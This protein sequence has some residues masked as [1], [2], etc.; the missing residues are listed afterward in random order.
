MA[1]N[2]ALQTG[3]RDRRSWLRIAVFGAQ[4]QVVGF[5]SGSSPHPYTPFVIAFHKC[6]KKVG[7]VE[8]QNVAMEYCWAEGQFDR[9][10]TFAADLVL[11]Q[12]ALIFVGAAALL[13]HLL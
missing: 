1:G 4:Q 8:G 12:V 11:R 13:W 10:Q 5:L 6:L 9:L 2:G 3:N 7:F